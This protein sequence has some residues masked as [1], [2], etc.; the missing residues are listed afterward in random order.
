MRAKAKKETAKEKTKQISPTKELADDVVPT[1][2]GLFS[3]LLFDEATD[4]GITDNQCCSRLLRYSF[5]KKPSSVVTENVSVTI[6]WLLTWS[7]LLFVIAAGACFWKSL[8][9]AN[10][11]DWTKEK[12]VN[13]SGFFSDSK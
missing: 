12:F 2:L 3:L 9:I 11:C 10:F 5:F 13:A 7:L 1:I 6:W 4:R 8:K